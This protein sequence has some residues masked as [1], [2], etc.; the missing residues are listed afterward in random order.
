[1]TLPDFFQGHPAERRL[2]GRWRHR[3]AALH[4][5]G[6]RAELGRGRGH[7]VHCDG[8]FRWGSHSQPQS[9]NRVAAFAAIVTAAVNVSRLSPQET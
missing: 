4:L 8:Q 5:P 7:R 3:C 6:E 9:C 1:M 2:G